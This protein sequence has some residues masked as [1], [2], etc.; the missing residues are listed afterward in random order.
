M[1]NQNYQFGGQLTSDGAHLFPVRVYYEDTDFSGNV[2]HAAYLK[3]FER[4]RTELLRA[5]NVHHETL[6][7]ENGVAFAVRSLNIEYLQA[8]HIDDLLEVSSQVI[9]M[10]GSRLTIE[11]VM[12]R[13]GD[14]ITQAKVVAV[15]IKTDGKPTRL[16]QSI[17]N[18]LE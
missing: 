1:D 17:R 6:L 15:A 12:R 18:A 9:E 4:A 14:V 7:A 2:Y 8:A 5:H 13:G 11:Q 10:K 3:F 16:P